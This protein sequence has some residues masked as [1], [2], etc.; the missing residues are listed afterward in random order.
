[1]KFQNR[2]AAKTVAPSSFVCSSILTIASSIAISVGTQGCAKRSNST[3]A[4]QNPGAAKDLQVQQS[5]I[6]VSIQSKLAS[7]L[8]KS[9]AEP[10]FRSSQVASEDLNRFTVKF[11]FPQELL[12]GAT[13]VRNLNGLEKEIQLSAVSEAGDRKMVGTDSIL[14]EGKNPFKPVF[15]SY[16]WQVDGKSFN[17]EAKA[18]R[19]WFIN[20]EVRLRELLALY[21]NLSRAQTFPDEIELEY[22]LIGESGRLIIGSESLKIRAEVISTEAGSRIDAFLPNTTRSE[23]DL[24]SAGSVIMQAKTMTGRL[25]ANL[26]GAK[27]RDGSPGA[28]R[29]HWERGEDAPASSGGGFGPIIGCFPPKVNQGGPGLKG[30]SGGRGENGGSGGSLTLRAPPASSL[31]ELDFQGIGGKGGTGGIGGHGSNGGRGSPSRT[32]SDHCEPAPAGPN[33]PDGPQ[34]DLGPPGADSSIHG[35]LQKLPMTTDNQPLD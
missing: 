27:G 25:I 4:H 11:E 19:S 5:E 33:G 14:V 10:T 12:K 29:H 22:F 13:I 21:P 23:L 3:N 35:T 24:A 8:Q 26:N 1:M 2:V 7:I 16:T 17:L 31:L 9:D 20:S 30:D 34:G 32:Y 15:I 6:K 28:Q 18:K